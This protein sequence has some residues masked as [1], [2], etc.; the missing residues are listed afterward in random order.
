MRNK[1]TVNYLSKI[2]TFLP[3]KKFTIVKDFLSIENN[4]HLEA[5]WNLISAGYPVGFALLN[6]IKLYEYVLHKKV[7]YWEALQTVYSIY[8]G[9]KAGIHVKK[10]E[11][12][13]LN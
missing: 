11:W 3:E 13:E 4:E 2:K 7:S 5:F 6:Y 9:L 12:Y 10:T 1:I 8:P